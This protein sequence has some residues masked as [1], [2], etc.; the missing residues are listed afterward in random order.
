CPDRRRSRPALHWRRRACGRRCSAAWGYSGPDSRPDR[1]SGP[2]PGRPERLKVCLEKKP[3]SLLPGTSYRSRSSAFRFYYTTDDF[4]PVKEKVAGLRDGILSAFHCLHCRPDRVPPGIDLGVQVVV[5]VEHWYFDVPECLKGFRLKAVIYH[6]LG[7]GED[8][9]IR[10]LFPIRH[11]LG[12][13]LG[14]KLGVAVLLREMFQVYC[15]EIQVCHRLAQRR[16][17]D[18]RDQF[19]AGDHLLLLHVKGYDGEL[20]DPRLARDA[21]HDRGERVDVERLHRGR[22]RILRRVVQQNLDVQRR[23]GMIA[24]HG[25]FGFERLEVHRGDRPGGDNE[26]H[27]F[28]T[29][30]QRGV[31]IPMEGADALGA[32]A[33]QPIDV[34]FAFAD[35][36]GALQ[37]RVAARI[38]INVG[39][40]EV[41]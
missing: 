7:S 23:I 3:A 9:R 5:H 1:T 16:E 36:E 13:Q 21:A 41:L 39:N 40:V 26:G 25:W 30:L 37:Q 6:N 11:F 28:V 24:I 14:E 35:V 29:R 32:V 33:E 38:L 12:D 2:L 17:I 15:A 22:A 31:G 18:L 10:A 27:R 19:L 4:G 8:Y 34:I 20:A